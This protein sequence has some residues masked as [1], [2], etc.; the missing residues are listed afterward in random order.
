MYHHKGAI[1]AIAGSA[2]ASTL[3][4]GATF[5]PSTLA[6]FTDTTTSTGNTATAGTMQIDVVDNSGTVTSAA[7]VSVTNASPMM[8]AM[9]QTL[10]LRNSGTLDASMRVHSL[11]VSASNP[12][13]NDVLKVDVTDSLGQSLYS[14]K[15]AD[16]DFL[17]SNIPAATT[18]NYTVKVT[19]P[20]DLAVDDNPYQGATMSFDL[21]ADASVIAGQ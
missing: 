19:W 3:A 1:I 5:A 17:V 13:L 6:A 21:T 18:Y 2:L 15:V 10:N 12:S 14:G 16:L 8:A 11:I 7:T 20:D 4:V 9:T